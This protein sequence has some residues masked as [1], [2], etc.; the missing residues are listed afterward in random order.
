VLLA[1]T[2]VP[3]GAD[4][5]LTLVG[6]LPLGY[7]AHDIILD[8][9]QADL[10]YVA[11]EKGLAV[12]NISDPINPVLVAT[13][14]ALR[15]NRSQ[16]LAQ[17]GSHLYLAAGKAGM[18]VIDVSNPADPVTIA[19]AWKGG[20]IYDVAVH[21]TAN[22]AYAISY[23]GELYVWDISNPAAPVFRQQIG[24]LHWR[25]ECDSCLA[26]M[27]D[28]T[29]SGGAQTV[30]VS[31][32]GNYVFAVDWNYGGMYAWDSSDPLH[33][34]FAGTHRAPVSFRVEADLAHDAIY[35]L[36][37]YSKT[38]GVHS[39][40]VSLLDPFVP[41]YPPYCTTCPTTC[42]VCDFV[43]SAVAMDGGGIGI[44]STGK[45][46]FYVG[47]RGFGEIRVLDATDPGN[48]VT[49]ASMPLGKH[50][51]KTAQGEGIVSR[52]DHLYAAVGL[53]GVRVY[54]FPGLSS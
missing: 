13:E 47:G 31:T 1:L 8:Q 15:G 27:R 22:A 37:T 30:G 42:T 21:P 2:V 6:S 25:G 20:T 33:L 39:V 23:G 18:Q 32:A 19:G 49:V 5:P 41:T 34:T 17:K 40:P 45:Y 3:G 16:G 52:G 48:L 26:R 12:V 36:G 14:P 28:L 29:P 46:V 38:S 7:R 10:A 9:A 43:P 11:T 54:R 50:Y 24:V 4:G 53:L 51:L 44:S 35:V